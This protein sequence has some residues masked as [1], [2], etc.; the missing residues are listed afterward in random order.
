M[1]SVFSKEQ[2]TTKALQTQEDDQTRDQDGHL[3]GL[4]QWQ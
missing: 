1:V 3:H 4:Q 2:E